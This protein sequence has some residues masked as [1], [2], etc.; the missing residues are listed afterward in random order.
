VRLGW[1]TAIERRFE[2]RP[3][4]GVCLVGL[5]CFV[6]SALFS[7]PLTVYS[8]W[9]L[10]SGGLIAVF[11]ALLLLLVP[12]YLMPLFNDYQ[13]LPP[14]EVR[15]AV[16]VLADE[17]G[18]PR[19]RIFM[20]DG[21]CQS[22]NFTANVS[23]FGPS[24]R[25]AIS[26]VALG[27]ASLDEVKAVTGHEIGHYVLGHV[28][29]RVITAALLSMLFFYFISRSLPV[30]A[31]WFGAGRDIARASGMPVLLFL[32]AVLGTL[33]EPI[34]NGAVRAGENAADQYSLD[35]VGLPDALATALLKTA[36]YRYPRPAAW[37][38]FLFYTHPSV[39]RR[40]RHAMDWKA[41]NTGG[42]AAEPSSTP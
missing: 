19:D 39:E 42:D 4:R 17:A 27:E 7:L 40:V 22:N 16:E 23:G 2:G 3:K 30:V 31:G 28:W 32:V 36:E 5:T 34:N 1:L 35:T 20:Y 33:A 29:N 18:I 37:E 38:E 8:A 26:D 13:P 24:A 15:D 9:W 25:I 41:A 10:W 12:A 11:I 21:S 6:L 14:G